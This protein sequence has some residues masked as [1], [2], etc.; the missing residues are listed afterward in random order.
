MNDE[1]QPWAIVFAAM[2]LSLPTARAQDAYV[3]N[4]GTNDIKIFDVLVCVTPGGV[5]AQC[6]IPAG[7][8]TEGISFTHDGTTAYAANG[9]ADTVA[10]IDTS[11]HQLLSAELISDLP[12]TVGLGFF[13]DSTRLYVANFFSSEVT[14]VNLPDTDVRE[15]IR[16]GANPDSVVILP[17][18]VFGVRFGRSTLGWRR[19]FLVD[20]YNVYRGLVSS[21]P[22]YGTCPNAD[23]P[24][25]QDTVFLDTELPPSGEALFYLV[26]IR[27]EGNDGILGYATDG[28]LRVPRPPCS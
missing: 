8:G 13:E 7:S 26:S 18:R 5:G 10:V 12:N 17:K 6:R 22:D 27:H 21:L 3:P 15:A 9:G 4:Q 16:T 24:D 20:S 19:N 25:L 2:L 11:T 23:D 14:A 28:T 1:S